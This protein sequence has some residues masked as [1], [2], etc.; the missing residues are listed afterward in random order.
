MAVRDGLA[1][2]A[3]TPAPAVPAASA[4]P[5]AGSTRP[6]E[7]AGPLT[8]TRLKWTSFVHS[9]VYIALL[10]CAF[11]AGS[12][13]PLTFVLGLAH[14]LLWIFMSL[15]CLAATRLRIVSLRLA[16]AVAVLGGIGPFFGSLEFIREQRQRAA[17]E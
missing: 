10:I 9:C 14:G 2:G 3:A 12:P 15:A 4:E 7:A 16:V 6:R 8:F 11:A 5:V 13:Q 1:A 17:I